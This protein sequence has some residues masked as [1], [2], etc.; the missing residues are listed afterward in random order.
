MFL[1]VG[2]Q[3]SLAKNVRGMQKLN[4]L[5]VSWPVPFWVSSLWSKVFFGPYLDAFHPFKHNSTPGIKNH[6]DPT[7]IQLV[8]LSSFSFAPLTTDLSG[9]LR[10]FEDHIFKLRLKSLTVHTSM[11]SRVRG[12]SPQCLVSVRH[13]PGSENRCETGWQQR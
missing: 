3:G 1:E 4:R 10:R 9:A 7:D 11:C 12:S 13:T 2:T 8:P 6:N 5:V